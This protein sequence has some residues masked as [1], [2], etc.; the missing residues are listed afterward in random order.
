MASPRP[1]SDDSDHFRYQAPLSRCGTGPGLIIIVD[2]DVDLRAHPKTLDPPPLEKWAEESYAVCQI[3][4]NALESCYDRAFQQLA[5]SPE[6][7]NTDK[8]G[9]V[10]R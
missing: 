1:L 8:V 3:R 5:D 4:M 9:I 2:A 6:C 7:T 10:S